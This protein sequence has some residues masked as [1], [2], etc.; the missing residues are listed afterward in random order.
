MDVTT[1]VDVELVL[2]MVMEVLL[3]GLSSYYAAVVT[4]I[5]VLS[6]TM[7]VAADVTVAII[8]AYGLSFF[9]SSAVA[10]VAEMVSANLTIG[11]GD[12]SSVACF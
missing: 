12:G 1:I 10:D 6:A 2:V 9:S 5:Q 8:V 11:I 3:S 7:A 4:A